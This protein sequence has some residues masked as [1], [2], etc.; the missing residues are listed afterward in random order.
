MKDK[1]LHKAFKAFR[2]CRRREKTTNYV[3]GGVPRKTEMS[4]SWVKS[5]LERLHDDLKEARICSERITKMFKKT[6]CTF[7]ACFSYADLPRVIYIAEY[8]NADAWN[9]SLISVDRSFSLAIVA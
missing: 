4:R 9:R 3:E 2:V 5:T 8:I 7:L 6:V 1:F